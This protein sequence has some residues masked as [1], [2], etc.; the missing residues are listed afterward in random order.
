MLIDTVQNKRMNYHIY[1]EKILKESEN[2]D[3]LP[4]RNPRKRKI[5]SKFVS[6][7]NIYIYIYIYI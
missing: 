5:P 2:L 4:L 1:L 6:Y 7:I 3:L